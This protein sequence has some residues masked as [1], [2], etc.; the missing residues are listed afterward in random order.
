MDFGRVPE[1]ELN[2]VVFELPKEPLWNKD[3]LKGE[4]RK[5]QKLISVV[6][7][8]AGKNGLGKFI[9]KGLRMHSF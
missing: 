5:I 1:N 7:N 9:Q 4:K 3:I 8:G 2:A 6:Q